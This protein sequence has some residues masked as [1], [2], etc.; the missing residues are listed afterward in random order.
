MTF[1]S[2]RKTTASSAARSKWKFA[3]VPWRAMISTN[4]RRQKL[5]KSEVFLTIKPR[6]LTVS[7]SRQNVQ[8]VKRVRIKFA[9]EKSVNGDSFGIC[10]ELVS[11]LSLVHF[12]ENFARVLSRFESIAIEGFSAPREFH[13]VIFLI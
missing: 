2:V 9:S 13:K 1:A 7:N 5:G 8:S 10:A 4:R 6:R 12:K 3:S 11:T